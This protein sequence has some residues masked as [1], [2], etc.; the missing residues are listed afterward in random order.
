MGY[1]S[2]LKRNFRSIS[3][4]LYKAPQNVNVARAHGDWMKLQRAGRKHRI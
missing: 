3:T 2:N 4:L 1:K